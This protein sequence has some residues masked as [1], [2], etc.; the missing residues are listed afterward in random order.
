MGSNL[1]HE[2]VIQLSYITLPH[3]FRP[4]AT[5]SLYLLKRTYSGKAAKLVQVEIIIFLRYFCS[6]CVSIEVPTEAND[7]LLGFTVVL[8][9]EGV[10]IKYI[11]GLI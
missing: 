8:A 5:K 6:E 11:T 7:Q 4:S 10:I 1:R 2:S 9:S 3:K